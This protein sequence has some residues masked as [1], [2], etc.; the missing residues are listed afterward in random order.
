[1]VKLCTSY[2]FIAMFGS[3]F[4]PCRCQLIRF[5]HYFQGSTNLPEGYTR[6]FHLIEVSTSFEGAF[7]HFRLL[8]CTFTSGAIMHD[9]CILEVCVLRHRSG[10]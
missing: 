10:I 9:V 7:V 1:M 8:T 4:D 6:L 3:T 5:D 2:I